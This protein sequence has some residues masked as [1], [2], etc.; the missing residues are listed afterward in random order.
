MPA[1]HL[2]AMSE[3]VYRHFANYFDN[4]VLQPYLFLLAQKMMEG[5]VC[6]NLNLSDADKLLLKEAG[7][8]TWAPP[9]EVCDQTLVAK[10]TTEQPF[11]YWKHKLYFQRY[12]KYERSIYQKIIQLIEG[13]QQQASAT[14]QKLMSYRDHIKNPFGA[15][16]DIIDWQLVAALSAALNSFT[17][18]TGG[19]GTGKTTSLGMTLKFLALLQPNLEVALAAP[20]GKAANRMKQSLAGLSWHKELEVTTIHRLLGTQK[21]SLY[22]KKNKDNPLLADVLIID[23]A[24]MV[25]LA[26]FAKLLEAVDATR[27]KVVL[28]GDRDQLASVEAGSLFGDLCLTLP[29]SNRF[30]S[31]R[32]EEMNALM[33]EDSLS[34]PG[35]YSAKG[36]LINHIVQLQISRRFASDRGIGKFS[37][38]IINNH[39]EGIQWFAEHKDE[40]L[41]IDETYSETEFNDF[42]EGY[43]AFILEPEPLKALDRL[44]ELRVL[45]V[46][47]QGKQG[48]YFLNQAIEKYLS[49]RGYLRPEGDFYEHRPVMVKHNYYDLELYNGDVGIV[50]RDAQGLLRVC[51]SVEK[52]QEDGSRLRVEKWVAPSVIQEVETCFAMTVHKSQGSEFDRVLMVLPQQESISLLTSELLYTG[53]TRAKVSVII[54]GKMDQIKKTAGR[55]VARGSG[56][57]DWFWS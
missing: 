47:R 46:L 15:P 42:V 30:S 37:Q 55:R 2:N 7:F 48:L 39:Q 54:Q 25:D 43:R 23:E 26:L 3:S 36:K 51:F 28:M 34:I 45:C 22:F 13:G 5:H 29:E 17:L 14:V 44:N 11:V 20:T 33:P 52:R 19:P 10:G 53:V 1:V 40:A 32:I 38:A 31:T 18:I 27:T 8:R 6:L 50:R 57:K 56:I 21:N 41:Q 16:S 24:S 4:K 49:Q 9:E 35:H 12:F